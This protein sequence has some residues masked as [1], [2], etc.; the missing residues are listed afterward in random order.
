MLP[1]SSAGLRVL[2]KPVDHSGVDL[3]VHQVLLES[4]NLPQG[5]GQTKTTTNRS[6]SPEKGAW[7]TLVDRVYLGAPYGPN[8]HVFFLKYPLFPY[9]KINYCTLVSIINEKNTINVFLS[10]N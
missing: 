8:H 1:C 3:R 7:V 9:F 2:E 5:V 10:R 4:H 6:P